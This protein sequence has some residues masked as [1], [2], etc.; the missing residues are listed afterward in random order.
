MIH[1]WI[2]QVPVDVSTVAPLAVGVMMVLM[3]S[4]MGKIRPNWFVGIRTPWTLSSKSSWVRTHRLGGWLLVGLGL[5]LAAAAVV[6]SRA[7]V[8][9]LIGGAIVSTLWLV[10]FSYLVWRRDP[11]KVAPAG[12]WPAD[13]E[14]G[15]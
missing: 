7:A 5:A 15:S 8:A 6:S 13:E 2:R 12:T 14:P 11:E 4:V 1:L 9:V 10:V 3:G